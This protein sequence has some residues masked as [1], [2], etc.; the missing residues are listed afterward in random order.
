MIFGIISSSYLD[1]GN[2]SLKSLRF[3]GK[4]I[5]LNSNY[6]LGS[7]EAF[8]MEFGKFSSSSISFVLS[9]SGKFNLFT[10]FYTISNANIYS[11]FGLRF[12]FTA[13]SLLSILFNSSLYSTGIFGYIPLST[14]L[15]N[16]SMSYALNGGC[17][18]VISYRTQPKDHTSLLLS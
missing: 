10:Y 13:M 14:F 5:V 9:S 6:F 4:R 17:N 1:F 15:N 3:Y 8:Y 18:A 11:Q 16:P 12:G 2:R 7:I